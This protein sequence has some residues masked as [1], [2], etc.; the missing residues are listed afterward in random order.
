MGVENQIM[1]EITRSEK[2]EADEYAGLTSRQARRLR[3][4]GYD[5]RRE[6]IPY[7]TR[8]RLN[9][10]RFARL[11]AQLPENERYTTAH[12]LKAIQVFGW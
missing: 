1:E 12:A 11:A 3:G 6:E 5:Q 8:L 9:G 7:R 10:L 4:Y 2:I